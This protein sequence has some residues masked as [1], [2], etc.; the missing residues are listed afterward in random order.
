MAGLISWGAI[1]V[2]VM[3]ILLCDSC[4][5]GVLITASLMLRECLAILADF[6]GVYIPYIEEICVHCS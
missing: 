5:C 6:G 3:E 1:N 4:K 2:D